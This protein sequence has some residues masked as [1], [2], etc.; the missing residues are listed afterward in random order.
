MFTA[1]DSG[2]LLQ[3]IYAKEILRCTDI[4]SSATCNRKLEIIEI[5]KKRGLVK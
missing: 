1:L 2:A 4:H 5:T 3:G